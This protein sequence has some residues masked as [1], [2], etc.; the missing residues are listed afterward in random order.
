MNVNFKKW[1]YSFSEAINRD[2]PSFNLFILTVFTC[3]FSRSH[4]EQVEGITVE[5]E[6]IDVSGSEASD[7]NY[8]TKTKKCV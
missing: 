8:N 5:M 2:L 6:Q 7:T 4:W 1:T 3:L